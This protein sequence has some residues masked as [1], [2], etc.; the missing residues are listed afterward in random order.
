[1]CNCNKF[2]VTPVSCKRAVYT[3]YV[4]TCSDSPGAF[5]KESACPP[6]T[7][8]PDINTLEIDYLNAQWTYQ[9]S[10]NDTG[11]TALDFYNGWFL[12]YKAQLGFTD[13]TIFQIYVTSGSFSQPLDVTQYSQGPVSFTDSS[14]NTSYTL[15]GSTAPGTG[16][17]VNINSGWG[18]YSILAV[19][20]DGKTII[21]NNIIAIW[22]S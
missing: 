9:M 10:A 17:A 4:A 5:L 21:F 3:D 19:G 13:N 11:R 22:G 2:L 20:N 1:M 8:G 18:N 6:C 7:D 12:P 16:M 14:G 15:Q